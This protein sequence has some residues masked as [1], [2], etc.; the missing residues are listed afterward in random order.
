ML[1]VVVTELV[2]RTGKGNLEVALHRILVLL[3]LL[4]F[5]GCRF[6]RC[7]EKRTV[8]D[9]TRTLILRHS[10]WAFPS[11][12]LSSQVYIQLQE[13]CDV[14][15]PDLTLSASAWMNILPSTGYENNTA[16]PTVDKYPSSPSHFSLF[17]HFVGDSG[18][19]WCTFVTY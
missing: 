13:D 4:G 2:S 16:P 11:A 5:R 18:L 3:R 6:F 12:R 19:C 8:A 10:W 15:C 7:G 9:V 14:L 17:N 1:V